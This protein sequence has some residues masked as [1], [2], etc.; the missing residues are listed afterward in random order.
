MMSHD[1]F[2][3]FHRIMFI[4]TLVIATVVGVHLLNEWKK[5]RAKGGALIQ[6]IGWVACV[7]TK[8]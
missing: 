6:T 8:K 4:V 2:H 5:C 1:A 7:E 3:R